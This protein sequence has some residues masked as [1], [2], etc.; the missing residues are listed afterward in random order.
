MSERFNRDLFNLVK[1][2]DQEINKFM[3]SYIP[4]YSV[5]RYRSMKKPLYDPSDTEWHYAVRVNGYYFQ[6]ENFQHLFILC[7]MTVNFDVHVCLHLFWGPPSKT[8]HS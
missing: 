2:S 6:E 1:M 3:D 4:M 5:I 8:F 7:F